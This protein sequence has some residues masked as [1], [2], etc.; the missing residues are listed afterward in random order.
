ML[1]VALRGLMAHKSRLITTFLAV[2]L[3]VAFVSGV[4]VLTDTVNRTFDDLFSDVF[5]DTDAVVRS[6]QEIDQGFGG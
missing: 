4:L 1:Q 5:R 3:G 2:A 6:N